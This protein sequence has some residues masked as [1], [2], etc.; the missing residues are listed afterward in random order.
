[1]RHYHSVSA[2]SFTRSKQ[3]VRPDWPTVVYPANTA[4]L[5]QRATRSFDR[6]WPAHKPEGSGR[7]LFEFEAQRVARSFLVDHGGPDVRPFPLV[8]R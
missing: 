2:G 7:R 1:L 8:V 6:H 3:P 4:A 5:T